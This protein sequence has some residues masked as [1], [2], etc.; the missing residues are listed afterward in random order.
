MI[1]CIVWIGIDKTWFMGIGFSFSEI[2][3]CRDNHQIANISLKGSTWLRAPWRRV[4][5]NTGRSA[6]NR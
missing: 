4:T 6:K 1:Y 5:L 3:K 2:A